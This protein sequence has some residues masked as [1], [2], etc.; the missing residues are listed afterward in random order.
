MTVKEEI[1][2]GM[3]FVRSIC[4]V[5]EITLPI[6]VIITDETINTL[7]NKINTNWGIEDTAVGNNGIIENN[8]TA[9]NIYEIT[10][11]ANEVEIVE[12]CDDKFDD[13]DVEDVNEEIVA[14]IVE[15]FHVF[16]IDIT[17]DD[18]YFSDNVSE[19]WEEVYKNYEYDKYYKHGHIPS[20]GN[21]DMRQDLENYMR[22]C[23][24]EK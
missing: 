19:T 4:I 5:A 15:T 16:G 10:I 7:A 1:A 6:G 14:D 9:F 17:K 18:I 20:L 8:D 24:K 12:W 2:V 11:D 23:M 22:E 3:K 13:S 21:Y